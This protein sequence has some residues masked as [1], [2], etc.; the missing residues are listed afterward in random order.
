MSNRKQQKKYAFTDSDAEAL[1]QT[2]EDML[3]EIHDLQAKL[4]DADNANLELYDDANQLEA[5]LIRLR[6]AYA[7]MDQALF[8]L[9]EDYVDLEQEYRLIVEVDEQLLSEEEIEDDGF[10]TY[11]TSKITFN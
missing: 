4:V 2:F 10:V 11:D 1:R 3:E 9:T 7:E 6:Q 8:D 5:Q